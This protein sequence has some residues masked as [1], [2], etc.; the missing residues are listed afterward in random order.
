MS[1]CVFTHPSTH[2]ITWGVCMFAHAAVWYIYSFG[3]FSVNDALTGVGG[4]CD[5]MCDSWERKWSCYHAVMRFHMNLYH[6]VVFSQ[7]E[8]HR[9]HVKNV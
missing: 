3:N 4:V 7:S 1:V 8:G 5:M 2:T 9:N 6:V